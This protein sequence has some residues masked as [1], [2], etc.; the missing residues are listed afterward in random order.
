[1]RKDD[2]NLDLKI[3]SSNKEGGPSP[4]TTQWTVGRTI[5]YMTSRGVCGQNTGTV[6]KPNTVGCRA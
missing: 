2:F 5:G 3:Q 6:I 1:M 4:R